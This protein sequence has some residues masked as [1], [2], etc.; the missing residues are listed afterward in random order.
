MS[1][2]RRNRRLAGMTGSAVEQPAGFV[3]RIA[4]I[5]KRKKWKGG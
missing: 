5:G 1:E 2:N 3:V 4:L